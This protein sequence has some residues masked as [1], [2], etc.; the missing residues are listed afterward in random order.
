MR[1]F[2][3]TR[4]LNI[5]KIFILLIFVLLLLDAAKVLIDKTP[6]LHLNIADT[7]GRT[8][9]MYACKY[10]DKDLVEYLLQ[11]GCTV[12]VTDMHQDTPLLHC[13]NNENCSSEM[14]SCLLNAGA[15]VSN[16]K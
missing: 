12:N 14:V 11:K 10:G 1:Y 13:I 4:F 7:D 9:L 3:K 6:K 5:F 8:P 15:N 2:F 16:I